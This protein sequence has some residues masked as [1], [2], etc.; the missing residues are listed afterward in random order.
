MD[1]ASPTM[2]PTTSSL[3]SVDKYAQLVLQQ[4][5]KMRTRLEF[6]DLHIHIGP[7]VFGAHKLLLAA[8]SPYFA[9]LLSGGLK[10]SSCDVVR[11]QGVEA[12]IFQLL[13]DFIYSGSVLISPE[14]VQE[15]MTAADMLQL[16]QVVALC[17]D[18]LKEQIDPGNCIGFFQ[19]S[20]QLSCQP[21]LEFTESYIQAHFP[22]VQQGDE[23]QLLTKEQL[24][25]LLRSE[26]LCIEDEHQVFAAAMSWLQKDTTARKRHVVEVLEPVRFSLLPPQRL[27]KNI[28]EVTDFSLRVALQTLLREYCEP[29]LSPKDKKLCSF[30]QTSRVRPRRKARK[31]LYA[32]GEKDSM[33]FDCVECYDPVTKQWSAVPSM[34]QPRCGLGVCSCHGAI[35]AMGGWVGAEIGNGIERFSPEDNAWQIVGQM[36]VPRYNFACCERQ[37]LIYVVGGISHAGIELS[38][39]EVFDPITRRWTSLP[40]MATRRAYLGA[41]CLD[42]CLFAV[43]GWDEHQ[44]SLNTVEKFSFE[45]EKWVEVA[46]MRIRRAGV[47]VISVNGLLYA[48][49]GRANVQN[50]SAPVTSDSVEVYNPHTDSWTEIGSMI[51]SRCEGSLA[52][53]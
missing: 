10:E 8:S 26:E 16:N 4:M 48:A 22:E 7:A 23:F 21:L 51:T 37:G 32:I 25:R 11:I 44:D 35:Y 1:P 13:L 14:N 20:E 12:A 53:L 19:F 2:A 33:I 9:A 6:C 5:N 17:C 45:E 47:S 36:A 50:F 18:F 42:D 3:R 24:I 39:V 29:S 43:G 31:F 15:L 28:E 49:G 30:L 52:V 34:N 46:P 38:S 40:P 27:Q 41:A